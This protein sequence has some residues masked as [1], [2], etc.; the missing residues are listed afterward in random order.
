MGLLKNILVSV[1]AILGVG[2]MADIVTKHKKEKEE[3]RQRKQSLLC[4]HC[5]ADLT[6]QDGFGEMDWDYFKC[7][8]CGEIFYNAEFTCPHCKAVL[9]DQKGFNPSYNF[10][11]CIECGKNIFSDEVYSGEEYEDTYWYCDKCGALLSVQ[12]GFQDS[13][14][15]WACEKC[16]YE[17]VISIENIRK[18]EQQIKVP[19]KFCTNC[20]KQLLVGAKF[21][22]VCGAP[23]PPSV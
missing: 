11:T 15:K 23:V 4:A 16:G 21:C 22:G 9:N 7:K 13:C 20:G 2:L 10:H 1:G 17:N 3:K 18:D 12:K 8:E 6:L 5:S 19:A 14:G